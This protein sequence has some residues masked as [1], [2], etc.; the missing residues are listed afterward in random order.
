MRSDLTLL[1]LCFD[2]AGEH[3][4]QGATD[5]G[6]KHIAR[7]VDV[8]IQAGEHDQQ[9]CGDK[10]KGQFRVLFDHD[11]GKDGR[12]HGVAGREGVVRRGADEERNV[13]AQ[14]ARTGAADDIFQDNIGDKNAG[15]KP[16]SC[17]KSIFPG[18]REKKEYDA[19]C[20]PGDGASEMGEKDH[21]RVKDRRVKIRTYPV[22][23]LK[24][25]LL[26]RIPHIVPVRRSFLRADFVQV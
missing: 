21:D 7:E 14:P 10:K 19:E 5:Q 3:A 9:S 26:D 2:S 23:Y 11:D 25:E 22:E 16:A 4:D 8:K 18:L 20:N 17:D 15:E 13:G 24:I 12:G 1:Y 6:E